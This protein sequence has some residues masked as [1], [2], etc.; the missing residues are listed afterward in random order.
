MPH[1]RFAVESGIEFFQRV[2]TPIDNASVVP[3]FIRAMHDAGDSR[4][5]VYERQ[6]AYF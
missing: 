3:C 2:T 4:D 5:D 1:L 6:R